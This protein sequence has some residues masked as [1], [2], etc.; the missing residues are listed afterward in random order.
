MNILK[1]DMISP[2]CFDR[3]KKRL[4]HSIVP[5]IA[6][7]AH[8]LN[9]TMLF[10]CFSK[11]ITSVLNSPVRVDNQSFSWFSPPERLAEGL[12]NHLL[13]QRPTDSPSD[14]NSREKVNKDRQIRPT[15][16]CPNIGYI[17]DTSFAAEAV[18]FRLSKF[19]ATG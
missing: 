8:T 5:T 12:K 19:G 9:E 17:T 6:F 2:L 7:T 3:L 11:F 15:R 18:K 13:A 10:K 14:N 4:G 1:I 16:L